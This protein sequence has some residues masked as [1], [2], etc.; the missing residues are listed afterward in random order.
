MPKTKASTLSALVTLLVE[1]FLP[2]AQQRYVLPNL[3]A[4]DWYRKYN[5]F[6]PGFLRGRPRSI[7]LHC[8]NRQS[9]GNKYNDEDWR[10]GEDEGVFLIQKST[11]GEL[12]K[13]FTGKHAVL[14][15]QGL[16]EMAP[17]LQAFFF[18]VF[19]LKEAWEWS[20][21]PEQYLNSAYLSTD[22]DA[23]DAFFNQFSDQSTDDFDNNSSADQANPLQQLI[24]IK[25]RC[26]MEIH[27]HET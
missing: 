10:T 5:E 23:T 17:S 8:L 6:V 15:V 19:K 25:V 12:W 21:L 20:A 24:P 18:A 7:I 3:R 27:E 4:S 22:K 13:K 16:D 2:D 1:R 11:C 26:D 9:R 14:F